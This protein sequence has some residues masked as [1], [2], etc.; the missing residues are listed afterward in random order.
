MNDRA[1]E[2]DGPEIF[3]ARAGGS[4]REHA[5][6]EPDAP[7]G[8]D[9]SLR[10]VGGLCPELRRHLLAA[11]GRAILELQTAGFAPGQDTLGA[12]VAVE[13]R[14]ALGSGWR[15]PRAAERE[16]LVSPVLEAYRALGAFAEDHALEV[17]LVGARDEH[18]GREPGARQPKADR[19]R[20]IGPAA[21]DG[22]H[23]AP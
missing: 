10:P 13:D 7:H 21:R 5:G 14:E 17:E 9:L 12:A 1:R 19:A 3:F 8:H 22:V 15:E 20:G 18:T 2:Q 11:P 16:R 6:V 4:Q 23:Y